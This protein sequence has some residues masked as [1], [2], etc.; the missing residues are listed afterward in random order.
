MLQ[1]WKSLVNL[2]LWQI[3]WCKIK[4]M[5]CHLLFIVNKVPCKVDSFLL[6]PSCSM[7]ISHVMLISL[8]MPSRNLLFLI[9]FY[10]LFDIDSIKLLINYCFFCPLI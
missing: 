4:L 8:T 9:V 1:Q 5:V 10:A 6:V 2:I 3:T 7:K